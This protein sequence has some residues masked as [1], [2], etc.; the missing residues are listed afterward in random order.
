MQQFKPLTS[1]RLFLALWVLC[2]HWFHA[3]GAEGTLFDIGFTSTWFD[4]GYLGVDGFFILSGFILAY[5]YDPA[6][7]KTISW[8]RFIVARIARIYPVYLVC[9]FAFALAVIA[10]DLL[11]H[12][13]NLGTGGY[14]APTF[15]RE[16][17]MLGAWRYAGESGW[18]DVDW[19]VSAEWFAYVFFPLF[20]LVAP[21]LSRARILLAGGMAL[22]A[23]AVVEATSPDHLSL[24]GGLARLVPEFLLGVLLCR[25]REAMPRH[26]GFRA[27]GMLSLC[28]CSLGISLGLDVLFVA[29]SAGLV[30]CLSYHKDALTRVLS[31]RS[32]V[33]LGEVSYCIYIV[34][35]IPQY[36]FEFARGKVAAVATLPGIVQ[37]ALLL[38]LTVGI[39]IVLHLAVE[40]PMRVYINRRIG[41]KMPLAKT[42]ANT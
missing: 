38:A 41:G 19:S 35:R 8:K 15:L 12:T 26:E 23:L 6:P 28:V 2:R 40:K 17:L 9:L 20:L 10:R 5:N 37:A 21:R 7:G 22:A 32:L 4:H 1:L 18:N 14:T 24:S 34:Q 16:M 39:A 13:H 42:L 11:L 33:F 30:F 31:L 27:G 36:M 25:L 29:G 3:Y